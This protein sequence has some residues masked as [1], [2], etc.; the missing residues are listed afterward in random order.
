MSIYL[1]ISNRLRED[2]RR[3]LG[4]FIAGPNAEFKAKKYI[5]DINPVKIATVGDVVSSTLYDANLHIDVMVV[6]GRTL[7]SVGMHYGFR[8]K[9]IFRVR[10]YPGTISID[11]WNTL[12]EAL[13][14]DGEVLVVV[15]GEEDLLLIPIVILAP[16][17]S[18]AIYGQPPLWGE[19]GIVIVR[20]DL[21]K[22]G[23]FI[24]YLMGMDVE[25]G[26]RGEVI[27]RILD[28]VDYT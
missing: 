7:R 27:R 1:K 3:P 13:R 21:E 14:I 25:G 23:E 17:N 10:N 12:R 2:L 28:E 5:E 19:G 20:V 22:K 6:D 18:V 26:D 8:P 9:H 4:Y 11:A 16:E 24:N 15:D